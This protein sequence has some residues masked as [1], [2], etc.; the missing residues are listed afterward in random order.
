[1]TRL[2]PT[3]VSVGPGLLAAAIM[4]AGCAST[5]IVQGAHKEEMV[6]TFRVTC[7]NPHKLTQDCSNAMGAKRTIRIA[8][9]KIKVAG[10]ED[11]KTVLIMDAHPLRNAVLTGVTLFM[12]DAQSEENNYSYMRVKWALEKNGIHILK[13]V[14]MYSTGSVDGYFLELDGDGYSVLKQYGQAG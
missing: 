12:Y 5:E 13:V 1:M 4:V 6:S 11:G 14:P 8:D 7:N 3:N 10:T 9:K 2:L